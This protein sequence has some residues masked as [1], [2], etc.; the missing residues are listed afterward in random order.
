MT[1]PR[2]FYR[3]SIVN[4]AFTLSGAFL[5]FDLSPWAPAGWHATP[6]LIWLHRIFP[7]WAL[8]LFFAVY[9]LLLLSGRILAVAVGDMLGAFLWLCGL[10]ALGWTFNGGRGNPWVLIAFF[11]VVVFH[12]AA[13]R[14]AFAQREM[15]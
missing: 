8:S 1:P 4:W 3:S 7:W 11:L 5:T 2:V 10:I 9:T 14:L 13:G 15:P 12:L 6:S